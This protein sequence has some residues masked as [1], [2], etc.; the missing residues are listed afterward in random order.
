MRLCTDSHLRVHTDRR[1]HEVSCS[2]LS[3]LGCSAMLQG[4]RRAWRGRARPIRGVHHGGCPRRL[5]V[6]VPRVL[7]VVLRPAA[8]GEKLAAICFGQHFLC[9]ILNLS[10]HVVQNSSE[11][12]SIDIESVHILKIHCNFVD[13]IAILDFY[14]ADSARASRRLKHTGTHAKA[15]R[16]SFGGHASRPFTGHMPTHHAYLVGIWYSAPTRSLLVGWLGDRRAGSVTIRDW[17]SRWHS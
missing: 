1:S 16:C 2:F 7:I 14:A 4:A 17:Q 9:A 3:A 13:Q 15:S 5:R 8:G 12:I 10:C 11:S 6:H